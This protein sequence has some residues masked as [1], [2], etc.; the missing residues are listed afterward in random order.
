[1]I[2]IELNKVNKYYGTQQ[3]L[4]DLTL[5][6][7]AGSIYGLLGPNGS[8]KTTTIRVINGVAEKKDGRI[9][10]KG[11][12]I[13][14]PNQKKIN[15]LAGILTE[16]AG[17][18]ETLTAMQ[19]LIFFGKLYNLEEDLIVERASGLMKKLEIDQAKDKKVKTFSTGMKKRLNLVRALLPDPEILF[20]DEPTSGLDPE[21]SDLVNQLI[22][23]LA[24]Q[25]K[26]IVLCTHQLRYAEEIC[27]HYGFLKEGHLIAEGTYVELLEQFH[28]SMYLRLKL[29]QYPYWLLQMSKVEENSVLIPIKDEKESAEIIKKL[30]LENVEVYFAEK[31]TKSLKDLYFSIVEGGEGHANFHES[32]D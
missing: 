26:T 29:S 22:L 3:V 27:T 23:E 16:N 12:E 7:P 32:N 15:H 14:D 25:G 24:Q 8:G 2:F 10:L 18:Y 30:V 6:I 28:E 4:K 31:Y 17:N 19:N 11:E 5:H 1:M 20:L 21:T 13:V 9:F